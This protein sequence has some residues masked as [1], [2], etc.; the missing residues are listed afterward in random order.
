MTVIERASESEPG[1]DTTLEGGGA[2][3]PDA[4]AVPAGPAVVALA[5]LLAAAGVIHLVMVPAHAGEWLVEGIAF[6]LAGWLQ[7][8][9]AVLL[10]TRPSRALLQVA[11]VANIVFVAA[12]ALTRLAGWPVG[13]E[14]GVAHDATFIDLVCVALELGCVA[15][16]GALLARPRIGGTAR[17][18]VPLV[19]VA[20]LLLAT[21]AIASPSAR[22]HDHGGE[23]SGGGHEHGAAADQGSAAHDEAAMA[24][25]E[26]GATGAGGA[27]ADDK[28][29]SLIMNGQGEGGGHVHSNEIVPVD[30]ATQQVLDGQLARVKAF[31]GRFPTVKDAEAGG[32]V[33]MGPFSPGLGAHY[34]NFASGSRSI[35]QP[36]MVMDDGALDNPTLIY[37]GITPES[38]LAGFMYLKFSLDTEN[39]PEGFAGPNDHWH[40]HT[41][42]CMVRRPGGGID[43]PLGAD[44]TATKELCDKYGGNLVANTGYM[45]HVWPV[46]GY[47]SPQGLFSNTNSKI[48]CPN[49]TYYIVPMD[50]VGNR[51]NVC[52]DVAP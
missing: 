27:P 14:A 34:M 12:W 25:H 15:L 4:P 11:V 29:L 7:L 23:A 22:G 35:T 47:E 3:P 9:L 30:A 48:A 49:G 19:P 28:G 18:L 39:P 45:V 52:K 38:K 24:G 37:D 13:P 46:P 41:N 36:S 26:H 50:E 44:T 20:A 6:A 40:F 5:S 16:A 32:Y 10:V 1:V 33:R 8:G 31:I 42:V 2:P 43:A 51:S 21:A 17:G